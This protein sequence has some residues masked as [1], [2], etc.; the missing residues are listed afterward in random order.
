MTSPSGTS[1]VQANALLIGM[2]LAASVGVGY[3]VASH[4]TGV[5][6]D[7]M[8]PWILARCLGLAAYVALA[9]LVV[10]GIWFRHPW[11]LTRRT[12]GPEALL[13][14]HVALA[15]STIALLAGHIAASALD[16]YAGVGWSGALIPWHATYRPTAVA[17][18]TIAVYGIV[19]VSLSAALAGSLARRVWLPIHSVAAVL[20]GVSLVHGLLAGSDSRVLWWLYAASGA[21]VLVLQLTRMLARSTSALE[22]W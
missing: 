8:L 7:R 9:A 17:L 14:M 1:R 22:A 20:F 2:V 15:A 4:S 19:L 3:V 10:L 6:H 18:G 21:V 16:R 11:R 12:P 5:L 13:R